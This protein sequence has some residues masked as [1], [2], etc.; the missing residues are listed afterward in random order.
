MGPEHN[1]TDSREVSWHRRPGL[2][3]AVRYLR[4]HAVPIVPTPL[5]D[6]PQ[7]SRAMIGFA[8]RLFPKFLDRADLTFPIIVAGRGWYQ[9]ALDGRHRISKAIWTG[10]THLFTVRVPWRFAL[11]LLIP[12]PYLAEW[13]F[14]VL[15]RELRRAGHWH[16]IR[17]PIRHHDGGAAPSAVP[18][19]AMESGGSAVPT[20]DGPRTQN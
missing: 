11:E 14:L 19:P 13:L 4:R 9:V 7:L 8:L 15:R 6:L 3:L 18:P 1:V 5:T 12:G 2:F 20:K 10:Q 16:P 17:H